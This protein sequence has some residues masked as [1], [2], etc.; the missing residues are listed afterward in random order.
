MKWVFFVDGGIVTEWAVVQ[1]QPPPFVLPKFQPTPLGVVFCTSVDLPPLT[2]ACG[3][4]GWSGACE[5][6]K[7]GEGGGIR[8]PPPVLRPSCLNLKLV[9]QFRDP[10]SAVRE[11]LPRKLLGVRVRE[12]AARAAEGI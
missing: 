10:G 1:N 4:G 8:P 11:G 6:S 3:G 2:P 12:A 5:I 9:L 7:E